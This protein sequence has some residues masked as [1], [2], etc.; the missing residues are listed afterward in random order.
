MPSSQGF[1]PPKM[2]PRQMVCEPF[3]K[4]YLLW[5][6]LLY[7]SIILFNASLI[8]SKKS[9]ELDVLCS[10][11]CS[12]LQVLRWVVVQHLQVLTYPSSCLKDLL[13]WSKASHFLQLGQNFISTNSPSTSAILCLVFSSKTSPSLMVLFKNFLVIF[14]IWF[15]FW[16]VVLQCKGHKEVKTLDVVGCHTKNF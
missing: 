11:S 12:F 8:I 15:I 16:L 1:L 14:P 2:K 5:L 6:W 10:C 7:S 4:Y 9:R 13:N 3:E